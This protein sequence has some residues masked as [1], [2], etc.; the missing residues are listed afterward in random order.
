MQ[1]IEFDLDRSPANLDYDWFINKILQ[2]TGIN[3][4]YYK[5]TQMERRINH[6][7]SRNDVDSYLE[8]LRM[9]SDSHEKLRQFIDW[10]T[11]NVSEFFRDPDRWVSLEQNILP[12]L[13]KKFKR[14]KIWSAG[15]SIG[16]EAYSMAILLTEMGARF[17]ISATDIDGQV[18]DIAR[19]GIYKGNALKNVSEDKLA[20][21]FEK[22]EGEED[23]Y[24]LKD[25]IRNGVDFQKR[26][27]FVDEFE[28]D[29]HMIVCRNVVIYFTPEAKDRLY[30]R[31][32][33][34]LVNDG[35]FFVGSTESL[36]NSR[37][38]NLS[39]IDTAFYQKIVK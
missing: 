7:M 24:R 23:S 31:F 36:L 9:I 6:L 26:D 30:K 12:F 25:L 21:Y 20:K 18:L 27:L 8:Y 10:V 29:F 19:D 11:I 39:R 15:C 4:A 38:F 17:D 32:V 1:E 3:L 34:S 2:L 13:I 28:K 33:G 14:L 35:I 5:K 37:D 22:Y 16:C